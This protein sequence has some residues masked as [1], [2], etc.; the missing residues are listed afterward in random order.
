MLP[1]STP[2]RWRRGLG[3]A[4]TILPGWVAVVVVLLLLP[5][6]LFTVLVV[7]VVAQIPRFGCHRVA[8][9]SQGFK[10]GQ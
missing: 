7:V 8:Q 3:T 10:H 1:G 5:I 6:R 2:A 9:T 4:P